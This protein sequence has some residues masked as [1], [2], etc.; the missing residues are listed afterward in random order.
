MLPEISKPSPPLGLTESPAPSFHTG[1]EDST[2]AHGAIDKPVLDDFGYRFLDLDNGMKCVLVSDPKA[3]KAGASM[4]VSSG[5]LYNEPFVAV[6]ALVSV[7]DHDLR[8][9]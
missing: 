1:A 3:E 9:K 2:N 8:Q 7:A 4:D 5:L 6:D